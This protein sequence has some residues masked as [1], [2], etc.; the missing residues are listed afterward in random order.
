MKSEPCPTGADFKDV[1]LL[2]QSEFSTDPVELLDLGVVQRSR[3]VLEY[4]ARVRERL[5]EHELKE[6]V[7]EVVVRVDVLSVPWRLLI[8]T[9][10]AREKQ[11]K[12]RA[13]PVPASASRRRVKAS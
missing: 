11:P 4:R 13:D 8:A 6:L 5:V 2:A 9:H 3:F 1:V 7:G 10:Y 12:S